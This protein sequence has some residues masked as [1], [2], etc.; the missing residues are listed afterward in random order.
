MRRLSLVCLLFISLSSVLEGKIYESVWIELNR[1]DGIYSPGDTA[2]VFAR[3]SRRRE[4][5]VKEVRINGRTVSEEEIELG[6]KSILVHSEVC[7]STRWVAIILHP[8]GDKTQDVDVGYVVSPEKF[9][10]A[11]DEPSD[12]AEFWK[13][14]IAKVRKKKMKFKAEPVV[15]PE[16]YADKVECWHVEI[17]MPEGW[18][19]NAYVGAPVGAQPGTLPIWIKAHGAMPVTDKGTQSSISSVCETAVVGALAMDLNAHGMK[20]GAP[21]SYYKELNDGILK[22]YANRPLKDRKS[23]YFRLMYLRL[24]RALDYMT[25]LP[26]WD[27]ERVMVSGGSQGGGQALALGGLDERVTHI[28]AYVPALCD[29]GAANEGRI[30]GWPFSRRDQDVPATELAQSILPYYDAAILARHFKGNLYI[31]VGFTDYTCPANGVYAAF[32]QSPAAIKQIVPFYHRHHAWVYPRYKTEY[33][34]II[35]PA[36]DR[37]VKAFLD[38]KQW[39]VQ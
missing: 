35:Q 24:V 14:E 22:D 16:K 32:N 38:K 30:G 5:M 31:E 21:A 18:P 19:V 3:S 28:R 37:F 12:F 39:T 1:P 29:L 11:Y 17:T 13:K 33:D 26:W 15:V 9:T 25:S 27:G 7:D 34:A 23:W 2:K 8:P 36:R 20:D 4:K 6:R 10:T